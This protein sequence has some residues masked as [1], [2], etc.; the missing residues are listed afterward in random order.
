M[1]FDQEKAK[2]AVDQAFTDALSKAYGVMESSI[3]IGGQ[4]LD[5]VRDKFA[6][7]LRAN[8][9]ARDIAL[10]VIDSISSQ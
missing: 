7:Q 10:A 5:T 2:A 8:A 3:A 9:A 6:V 4:T 1:T